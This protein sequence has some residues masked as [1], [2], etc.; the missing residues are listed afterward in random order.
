MDLNA[1]NIHKRVWIF[2]FIH[3]WLIWQRNSKKK[4]KRKAF[5][6]YACVYKGMRRFW[7]ISLIR[8]FGN[9]RNDLWNNGF[10][11]PL[12]SDTLK[13]V[14]LLEI[15]TIGKHLQAFLW[16][17]DFF[18][19]FF[20]RQPYYFTGICK[21]KQGYEK[22][23]MYWTLKGTSFLEVWDWFHGRNA[24][25]FFMLDLL[26]ADMHPKNSSKWFLFIYFS[27]ESKIMLFNGNLTR[28]A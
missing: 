5:L 13:S 18:S 11:L 3:R 6:V 7:D 12:P 19:L 2:N 1:S 8:T 26:K 14:K 24:W 17:V 28:A 20:S 23:A 22:V 25:T 15:L 21:L 27:L 9:T 10:I 4:K 16:T